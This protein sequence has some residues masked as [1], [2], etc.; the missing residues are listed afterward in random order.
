MPPGARFFCT[1][2]QFVFPFFISMKMAY[3][4][5]MFLAMHNSE[6]YI[7]SSSG[8]EM[9]NLQLGRGPG[10]VSTSIQV[11]GGRVGNTHPRDR[12]WQDWHRDAGLYHGKGNGGQ[13]K[14]PNFLLI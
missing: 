14:G 7:C 8:R 3:S 9:Q 13:M 5:Y 12:L 10:G 2:V 11:L 1:N 6:Q 4:Q